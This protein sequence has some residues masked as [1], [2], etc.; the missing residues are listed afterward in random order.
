MRFPCSSPG[1][2]HDLENQLRNELS[3]AKADHQREQQKVR[4]QQELLIKLRKK[5]QLVTKE[6]DSY[7]SVLSSY[8]SEMTVNPADVNRKQLEDLEEVLASYRRE[9]DREFL[10]VPNLG[11]VGLFRT[12]KNSDV[13]T[14]PLARPFARSLAHSCAGSAL[15]A[16]LTRSE[17]LI[18]SLTHYRARWK[19]VFCP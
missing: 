18:H 12:T 19:G 10:D 13:S 2:A 4:Q 14:G 1:A 16:G 15:L 9:V 5:Y 3:S 17:A 8:E 6:R 7:R 11:K